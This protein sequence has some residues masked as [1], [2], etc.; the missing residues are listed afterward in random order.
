MTRRRRFRAVSPWLPSALGTCAFE[1]TAS[2]GQWVARASLID[3]V[4]KWRARTKSID[5][6]GVGVTIA[7]ARA[8]ADEAIA[9]GRAYSSAMQS[10]L[11]A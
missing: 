5:V 2:D 11:I 4:Y 10:Q 9:C 1:R 3:G 7:E 8:L 6:R